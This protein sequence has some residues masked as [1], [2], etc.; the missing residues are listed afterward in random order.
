MM[1]KTFMV[2]F[3]LVAVSVKLVLAAGEFDVD[4]D[5]YRKYFEN[6]G[7]NLE[8]MNPATTTEAITIEAI[9]NVE[10]C[11]TDVKL[12]VALEFKCEL[13]KC[14]ESLGIEIS[15][16][17]MTCGSGDYWE[18]LESS[19]ET[20]GSS[21]MN[22]LSP[23][24]INLERERLEKSGM[25]QLDPIFPKEFI[26]EYRE[27]LRK[28]LSEG[29]EYNFILKLRELIKVFRNI[30]RLF[31]KVEPDSKT[32]VFEPCEKFVDYYEEIMIWIIRAL[33]VVRDRNKYLDK[34]TDETRRLYFQ[35]EI[36]LCDGS[37]GSLFGA[38]MINIF[39][40]PRRY[41]MTNDYEFQSVSVGSDEND[42]LSD[43]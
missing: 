39:K 34:L 36:C 29:R 8:S 21:K 15:D 12:A 23:D 10:G 24:F 22:R 6:E 2:S 40:N 43:S 9:R 7:L 3:A 26:E 32:L 5:A 19:S 11:K 4:C 33:G 20:S 30:I 28:R 37:S 27:R 41:G 31:G 25:I 1:T 42:S 14:D 13:S 18:K 35:F 16:Y 17:V 38:S